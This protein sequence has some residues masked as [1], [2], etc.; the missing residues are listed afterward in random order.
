[1]ITYNPDRR[2][3]VT[4]FVSNG[5]RLALIRKPHFPEG[6][7]R[8][9]GGGI[10]PGEDFV[11]GVVREAR[12]E[13]GVEVEPTRYLVDARAVFRFADQAVPWR[14]HVLAATTSERGPGSARHGRDRRGSLGHGGRARRPDPRTAPR[15]RPRPLA[16]PRRAARRRPGRARQALNGHGRCRTRPKP[17]PTP[18]GE[19]HAP[20]PTTRVDPSPLPGCERAAGVTISSRFGAL[21][22]RDGGSERCGFA[23]QDVPRAGAR[24]PRS[25]ARCRSRAGGRSGR[26]ASCAR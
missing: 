13:L 6:I 4:L 1:M 7:W 9:P 14:T 16:L 20:P 18:R 12:E 5:D 24:R 8:T 10:K 19:G 15:D 21:R 17:H 25:S 11:A 2:H 23:A 3:D 22:A 26:R